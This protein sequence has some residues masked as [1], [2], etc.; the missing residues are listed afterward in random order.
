MAHTFD[1]A[2]SCISNALNKGNSNLYLLQRRRYTIPCAAWLTAS[3][4]RGFST[5]LTSTHTKRDTHQHPSQ[6]RL[7]E[8]RRLSL[9]GQCLVLVAMNLPGLAP[10]VQRA[11]ELFSC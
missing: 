3:P 8:S 6:R 1:C 7:R 5:S 10:K 9:P 2:L 4:V 11:D